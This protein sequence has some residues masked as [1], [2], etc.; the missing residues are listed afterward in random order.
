MNRREHAPLL[1]VLIW[2]SISCDAVARPLSRSTSI[3]VAQ[4]QTSNDARFRRSNE[5]LQRTFQRIA[6]ANPQA[7]TGDLAPSSFCIQVAPSSGARAFADAATR[8]I[9]VGPALMLRMQNEDQVAWMLS[10][11]LAHITM[12]HEHDGNPLTGTDGE[13]I[14]RRMLRQAELRDRVMGDKG[15]ANAAEREEY[16]RLG[17][18]IHELLSRRI[19]PDAATNWVENEAD[20]VALRLYL[21]AG[22][23]PNEIAWRTDQVAIARAGGLDV[24]GPPGEHRGRDRQAEAERLCGLNTA[25]GARVAPR[26]GGN[27]YPEDCWSIWNLRFQQRREDPEIERL[28][29]NRPPAA[30]TAGATPGATLADSQTELR[31]AR[32]ESDCESP[33]GRS[34]GR[35][36]K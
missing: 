26:R 22:F 8:T 9:N 15:G 29:T 16:D 10:H 2:I 5:L 6:A 33:S 31:R 12:R 34:G 11:E 35:S 28:L 17:R 1:L 21:T 3:P 13:E 36:S 18:E 32:C 7:F 24:N 23:E 30:A 14:R 4:C 20:E 25:D 27:R 19:G